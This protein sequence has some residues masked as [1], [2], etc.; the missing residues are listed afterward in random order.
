MKVRDRFGGFGEQLFFRDE[1]W[2]EIQS[3]KSIVLQK[4]YKILKQKLSIFQENSIKYFR[5]F[6]EFSRK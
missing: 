5:L 6:S 2:R 4:I 1:N 3:L